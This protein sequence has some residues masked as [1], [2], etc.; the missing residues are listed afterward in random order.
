M[1]CRSRAQ[2]EIAHWEGKHTVTAYLDCSKCY[3]RIEHETAGHRAVATGCPVAI[4]N[5]AMSIY[6]GP[7]YIRVHGAVAKAARGRHGL[8]AGCSFAKDILK[9]FLRPTAALARVTVFRD[10]VDDMVITSTG[11]NPDQAVNKLLSDLKEL[12][13][14]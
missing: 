14:G 12:R 9:A 11:K 6:S 2:T 10:Y 1:A 5:M 3:E 7:R 13:K 4:I 8:I